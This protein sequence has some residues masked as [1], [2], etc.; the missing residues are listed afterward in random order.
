ME[1]N[2]SYLIIANFKELPK[3][4]T[5]INNTWHIMS[6][7]QIVYV[8]QGN[9]Q[10]LISLCSPTHLL[11]LFFGISSD[12]FCYILQFHN[13]FSSI[14]RIFNLITFS[15]MQNHNDLIEIQLEIAEFCVLP[16]SA[17]CHTA[18]HCYKWLFE[19]QWKPN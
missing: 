9:N 1:K 15:M 7:F 11:K 12:Y 8:C 10:L 13:L 2:E 5:S 17:L 3:A 4:I 14:S 6:L 19:F 18:L 16:P